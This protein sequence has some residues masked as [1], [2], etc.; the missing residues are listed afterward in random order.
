LGKII[1]ITIYSE[2]AMI[3]A[4]EEEEGIFFFIKI[5]DEMT[6]YPCISQDANRK[7]MAHLHSAEQRKVNQ[8]CES[9][10]WPR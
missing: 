7:H 4:P 10:Q 9:M 5:G 2:D 3:L 6:G 8:V 1:L